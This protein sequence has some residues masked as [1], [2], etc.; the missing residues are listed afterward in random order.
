MGNHHHHHHHHHHNSHDG[1]KNI[2]FAFGLNFIFAIIEFIGGWYTNSVAIVSDAIHDAGDS[3]AL[4][5]AYFSEKISQRDPNRQF[6]YGHG[7]FSIV[8]AIINGVILLLGSVFVLKEAIERLASP[9]PVQPGGMLVL[10]FLGIAVNG[11]AAYRLSKEVGFNQKMVMYHLIEDLLGWV[12][13]LVVSIILHFKPWYILDSILSILVSLL[14]LKGVYKN[15]KKLTD[16]I[17]QKFPENISIDQIE[18]DI[19]QF[20][21]VLD[22]HSIRGWAIDSEVSTLTLHVLVPEKMQMKDAD[23]LKVK[24]LNYLAEKNVR[25]VTLQIESSMTEC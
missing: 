23:K 16:I 14:I 18:Q 25:F 6:T 19:G 15:L 13:V 3:L 1:S 20:E 17:L 5:F 8:A 11:W 24:I 22:V 7:R 2:L 4:L 10:A 12:S 9:E 21:S